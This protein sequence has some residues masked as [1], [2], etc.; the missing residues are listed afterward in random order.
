MGMSFSE[1]TRVMLSSMDFFELRR[2]AARYGVS[3]QGVRRSKLLRDLEKK[4]TSKNAA[5][6]AA[7]EGMKA[8]SAELEVVE[9]D[10]DEIE[11]EVVVEAKGKPGKK[12]TPSMK[13]SA[14]T[15]STGIT[16]VYSS[17]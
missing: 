10:E 12:A 4:I 8:K 1:L 15:A 7:A 9:I 2:T 6:V 3:Y 5:D 11:E 17:K 14:Y 16:R 13:I